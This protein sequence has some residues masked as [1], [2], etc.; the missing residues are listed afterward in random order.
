[1]LYEFRKGN[2]D[3]ENIYNDY[4]IDLL[5]KTNC[6]RWYERFRKDDCPINGWSYWV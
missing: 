1:M 2:S 3:E 6:H 5:N 4:R